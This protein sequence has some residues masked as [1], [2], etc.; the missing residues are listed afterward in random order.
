MLFIATE[1]QAVS[2]YSYHLT[3]FFTGVIYLVKHILSTMII[4]CPPFVFAFHPKQNFVSDFFPKVSGERGIVKILFH[5][6][7]QIKS[8]RQKLF[9]YPLRLFR[10][11]DDAF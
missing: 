4:I 2:G 10:T 6:L 7:I 3:L 9:S 5:Y 11:E 8:K 1:K